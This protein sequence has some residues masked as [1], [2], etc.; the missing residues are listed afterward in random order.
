MVE[1]VVRFLRGSLGMEK[2]ASAALEAFVVSC[3]GSAWVRVRVPWRS[4]VDEPAGV[5]WGMSGWVYH[6]VELIVLDV[7]WEALTPHIAF[8]ASSGVACRTVLAPC[9]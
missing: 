4:N 3:K 9:A 1:V 7:R 8:H 2:V 5:A 6:G